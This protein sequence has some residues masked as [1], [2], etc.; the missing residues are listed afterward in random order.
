[1]VLSFK[2]KEVANPEGIKKKRPMVPVTF[3]N[4]EVSFETLALL[5]SGADASAISKEMAEVLGLDLT[6]KPEKSYG[7]GGA[8]DTITSR[9]N[10]S[11]QKGHEHYIMTVDVRVIL[12]D[13]IQLPPL[14]GRA[15]FFDEF[16]IT[17]NDHKKKIT[18]KK[19]DVV[20]RRFPKDNGQ[21]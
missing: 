9:V 11:V 3:S 1:M 18:L 20:S 17:F 8:V 21:S 6:G 2:Y 15:G 12:K 13:D 5:D 4:G 10:I 16:E 7:I 14:L 19:L